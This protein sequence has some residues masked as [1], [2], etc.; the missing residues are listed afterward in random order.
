MG[1]YNKKDYTTLYG[2]A[3]ITGLKTDLF[4]E[5]VEEGRLELMDGKLSRRMVDL[6][7][8]TIDSYI[9][10]DAYLKEKD[11][12][13]FKYVKNREKY[14]DYLEDN[15]YFGLKM[16]YPDEFC[17]PY[18]NGATFYFE[19]KDAYLLDKKSEDFFK[20]FGL[21]EEDKCKIIIE[22]CSNDITKRLLKEFIKN[23]ESYT[24][25]VTTFVKRAS[26]IDVCQIEEKD[27]KEVI[28]D[29]PYVASKDLIIEFIDFSKNKLSLDWGKIERKDNYTSRDIGAYPYHVYVLIAKSIFNEEEI[30]KN[31]VLEKVFEKSLYYEMWLYLSAHFV[32][33]WRSSDICENWPHPSNETLTKLGID[34]ESIKDDVLGDKIDHSIYVELGSFIEKSI[35]ISAV[36]AHKTKKA[37]D[38]LAPIGNELKSFF[39]R[40][41]LISEYHRINSNEGK[42]KCSRDVNY[43]NFVK[44]KYLFGDNVYNVM[45]RNNL[46]SIRLN[47]SF[48]QSIEARARKEGS[49][50][51]AAYT[52]ASYARNHSNI[53][54]TAI[55]IYDHG[56]NGETAEVVLAMMM[57]RGVFGT[58]RYKEFLSAF[59]DA[60]GRLTAQEQ[61][62]VLAEC[63]VSSYEL[64]V[65]GADILA[66][67][68]L[69]DS[70]SAGN[71]KDTLEILGEM[72]EI[73]QGF[74]KAKDIGIY[75]KKRAVGEICVS[76]SFESCIANVCP[77]LVFG[78][79]GIKSL[80][81]V[82]KQYQNKAIVTGNSKYESILK[83]VILPSYKNILAEISKR[84]SSAE[85]GALKKAI[86]E[87]NGEYSEN[88]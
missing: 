19:K 35:E 25:S 9:T 20:F 13:Q 43:R 66:E 14:I 8:N 33:G 17:F 10:V 48:L 46:S 50:T 55:Y 71:T 75:C 31:H 54:T 80:V 23:I 72:F 78:E 42:L 64:E 22:E 52:I 28:N 84:M 36:K 68:A 34:F 83:N 59:P 87:Y 41:V 88:N 7:K 74:G 5:W 40:M 70:F 51:M 29:L 82:V 6:I 73:S 77:Y 53:D 3:K 69:I 24:P 67:Q 37:S 39:G 62:R 27:I 61:T 56:L 16:I 81:K 2:A 15:D 18:E 21:S 30:K 79:A 32:C 11:K 4:K 76:P 49:G 38:L 85:K 26:E 58:I 57:D 63:D 47:K 44:F 12:E 1:G 65:V 86:G 60:F 45:G